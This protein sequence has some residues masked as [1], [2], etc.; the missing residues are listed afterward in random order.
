[1]HNDELYHFYIYN[2]NI[3]NLDLTKDIDD[4]ITILNDYKERID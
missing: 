1:M 2:N 4:I 3:K